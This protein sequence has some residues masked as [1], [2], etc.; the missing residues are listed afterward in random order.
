VLT[1]Y[2]KVKDDE[3]KCD[4]NDDSTISDK[5]I[6]ALQK[7]VVLVHKKLGEREELDPAV[8][9][10]SEDY[11]MA[12]ALAVND[13]KFSA[14][15]CA[16][17]KEEAAYATGKKQV[18]LLEKEE[19]AKVRDDRRKQVQ[20][21]FQKKKQNQ[22][23][24]NSIE[25]KALVKT[26]DF[27]GGLLTVLAVRVVVG[28]VERGYNRWV[29]PA[30]ECNAELANI[31]NAP[32]PNPNDFDMCAAAC[33]GYAGDLTP[34]Q[35]RDLKTQ[36]NSNAM[37]MWQ[38]FTA[39]AIPGLLTQAALPTPMN[40]IETALANTNNGDAI[41]VVRVPCWTSHY[42]IIQ[43]RSADGRYRIF[44]SFVG[45][46][47][48]RDWLVPGAVG[49]MPYM[50]VVPGAIG[51]CHLPLTAGKALYGGGAYFNPAIAWRTGMNN[52]FRDMHPNPAALPAATV[53]GN[54][55]PNFVGHTAFYEDAI[56]AYIGSASI[57]ALRAG[58]VLPADSCRPYYAVAPWT[59]AACR[60]N[61]DHM[62][63]QLRRMV[64]LEGGRDV[65][66]RVFISGNPFA[67]VEE[68]S[69]IQPKKHQIKSRLSKMGNSK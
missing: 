69:T 55:I 3:I 51:T 43:R 23:T 50:T 63:G 8:W 47:F 42:F 18:S 65:A 49:A 59:N 36:C 26:K 22:Q 64:L 16:R 12:L 58:N 53:A 14:D 25:N 60:T 6:A 33:G 5:D 66:F 21:Q 31:Y 52:F 2:D 34:A 4:P 1:E 28:L 44:Q 62:M 13:F 30:A 24:L 19:K 17:L 54:P 35:R 40:E 45:N 7:L 68:S 41:A 9:V 27:T 32:L 67:F 10:E 20:I 57:A 29:R 56:G 11:L 38:A 37:W 15:E 46:Y 39:R 48:A 61:V